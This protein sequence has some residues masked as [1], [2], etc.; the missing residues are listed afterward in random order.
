MQERFQ[1]LWTDLKLSASQQTAV[2]APKLKHHIHTD[3]FG[4][5]VS[6]FII[7]MTSFG[8][9]QNLF[10][11]EGYAANQTDQIFA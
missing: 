10:E 5:C 3:I 8:L 4:P 7:L 2:F 6:F 11:N 1:Q 9:F